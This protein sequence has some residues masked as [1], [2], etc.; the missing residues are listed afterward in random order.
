MRVSYL[1]WHSGDIQPEKFEKDCTQLTH[2]HSAAA[3]VIY[4]N[5]Y[6]LHSVRRPEPQNTKPHRN[7]GQFYVRNLMH[8][9]KTVD[10]ECVM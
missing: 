2:G 6:K 7:R 5:H 9:T 1:V 4:F 8:S 3:F 10:R